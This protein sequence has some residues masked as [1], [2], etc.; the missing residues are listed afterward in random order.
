MDTNIIITFGLNCPGVFIFESL[1]KL[2]IIYYNSLKTV[3]LSYNSVA[4]VSVFI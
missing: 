1:Y 4:G 3:Q 2:S